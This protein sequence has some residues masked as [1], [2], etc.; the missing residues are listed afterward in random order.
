MTALVQFDN[1]TKVF[2]KSIVAVDNVSLSIAEG[3]FVTLLGPSGCG[4]TTLLRM[5]AGFE[6]PTEGNIT[7]AGDDVTQLP[8]Y[9]RNVNMV[10]QD[11]ALF[12]HLTVQKNVAFGLER[13]GLPREEISSKVASTLSL[14]GLSDKIEARPYELS[15]G[16]RQRVALA[17]AIVR[18]PKVL[19]LD[20]PLSS[21]DANLR[22][23]M[24]VELKHLHEQ[25]GLT[26]VLVTHDQTEALVM[27]D[28]A[29]VMH[30]GSISQVGTPAELY[31]QPATTYVADFVGTSNLLKGMV[32]KTAG[33]GAEVAVGSTKLHCNGAPELSVGQDVI[34]GFRPEKVRVIGAKEKAPESW[35]VLEC[36]ISEVLFHGGGIR[37]RCTLRDGEKIICDVQ[38]GT[39]AEKFGIPEAGSKIKLAIDPDN[40]SIFT[41]DDRQ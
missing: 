25:L 27:S 40:V 1:V 26:F 31:D 39:T 17:R 14:V 35:D 20:E 37:L 32:S 2:G 34:V 23:A 18:E 6:M 36:Q 41:E 3:E 5:L 24:Q 28:R 16:Q 11:Y 7:L 33:T 21:L 4:K 13:L 8:P 29:V 15:G 38:L 19:L 12:P 9:R 30:N 10:F 22:E